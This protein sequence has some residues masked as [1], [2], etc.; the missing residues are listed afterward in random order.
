MPS[1]TDPYLAGSDGLLALLVAAGRADPS[2]LATR[3]AEQRKRLAARFVDRWLPRE[4]LIPTPKP[5]AEVKL[6]PL[7]GDQHE[8]EFRRRINEARQARADGRS[9]VL[10]VPRDILIDL[11]ATDLLPAFNGLDPSRV[12]EAR[13]VL[14]NA[15]SYPP[16]RVEKARTLLVEARELS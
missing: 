7:S 11:G 15:G 3:D 13:A 12:D 4:A 16:L 14:R 10:D 9:Y 1:I 5:S 6:L 8:R 2:Y